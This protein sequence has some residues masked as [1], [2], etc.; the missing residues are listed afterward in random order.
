MAER[1]ARG[2]TLPLLELYWNT[3]GVEKH[4]SIQ[5]QIAGGQTGGK[6]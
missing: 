3:T 6:G 4:T 1:T 5:A 2:G